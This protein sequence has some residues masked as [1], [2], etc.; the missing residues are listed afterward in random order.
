MLNL[1]HDILELCIFHSSEKASSQWF[2]DT[3]FGKTGGTREGLSHGASGS[4]NCPTLKVAIWHHPIERKKERKGG[5]GEEIKMCA[6]ES[7]KFGFQ[8]QLRHV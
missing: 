5:R 2:A 6:L 1:I 8:S 7:V 4:V 3:S